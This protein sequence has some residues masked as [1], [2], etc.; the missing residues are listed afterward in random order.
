MGVVDNNWTSSIFS[1]DY[2]CNYTYIGF[3][4]SIEYLKIPLAQKKSYQRLLMESIAAS[5]IYVRKLIRQFEIDPFLGMLY[6]QNRI[7]PFNKLW[8]EEAGKDTGINKSFRKNGF[9]IRS[10]LLQIFRGKACL[11]T[12]TISRHGDLNMALT[13][14][15]DEV[16]KIASKQAYYIGNVTTSQYASLYISNFEANGQTTN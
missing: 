13:L 5:E 4:R 7:S 14:M 3:V 10:I 1:E 8:T 2:I 12:D 6:P 9:W 15:L 16:E 11:K